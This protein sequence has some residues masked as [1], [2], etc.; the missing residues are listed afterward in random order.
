M[1]DYLGSGFESQ[2][3]DHSLSP[4]TPVLTLI[5]LI[6]GPCKSR[7]TQ[8]VGGAWPLVRLQTST[9]LS[10]PSISAS[11]KWGSDIKDQASSLFPSPSTASQLSSTHSCW[12]IRATQLA[13][14][15]ASVVLYALCCPPYPSTSFVNQI[16]SHLS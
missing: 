5:S 2:F 1:A 16:K 12:V 9:F 10:E 3:R 11:S 7:H 13:D 15:P 4:L 6:A 14:L 8:C